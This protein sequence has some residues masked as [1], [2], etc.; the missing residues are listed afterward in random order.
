MTAVANLSPELTGP[1][2]AVIVGFGC[3]VIAAGALTSLFAGRH[4]GRSLA[5]YLGVGLEFFLAA[6]LIRLASADTFAM[7]GVAAT[8]IVVRRTIVLGLG[9]A[10]RAAG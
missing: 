3:A 1:I 4:T 5:T 7:L 2:A 9:Y 10:A 8:I 6:G